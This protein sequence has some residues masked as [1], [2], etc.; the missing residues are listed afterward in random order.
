MD[1]DEDTDEDEDEVHRRQTAKVTEDRVAA[2]RA[3]MAAEMAAGDQWTIFQQDG[4]NHLGDQSMAAQQFC[5][6]QSPRSCS[7]PCGGAELAAEE[8][9][10]EAAAK[11]AAKAVVA[12]VRSNA[13][14]GDELFGPA[15][16][17]PG[18][19]RE[20][21][22]PAGATSGAT[23]GGEAVPQ[24]AELF[25]GEMG[26][27][28]AARQAAEQELFG[29]P[30]VGARPAVSDAS[31]LIDDE[32]GRAADRLLDA[33]EELF[34]SEPVTS[35]FFFLSSFSGWCSELKP[36]PTASGG[37]RAG[38]GG[39]VCGAATAAAARP[40]VQ[41]PET[42]TVCKRVCAAFLPN[43]QPDWGACV[44]AD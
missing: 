40:A 30:A 39:A 31:A 36:V 25:E 18:A 13:S 1:E 27:A 19:R 23:G 44:L 8:Q 9:A 10:A 7:S 33:A 17:K 24:F 11:A 37:G 6:R 15:R 38:A 21:W 42:R 22:A 41:P 26:P 5:N 34:G 32:D 14:I 28:G 4:P 2:V 12:A 29:R 16:P 43:S 3:A 35:F 20:Y